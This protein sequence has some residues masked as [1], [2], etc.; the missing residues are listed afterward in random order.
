M[1]WDYL[2][3]RPDW[4]AWAGKITGMILDNEDWELIEVMKCESKLKA[5]IEHAKVVLKEAGYCVHTRSDGK[6]AVMKKR[7]DRPESSEEEDKKENDEEENEKLAKLVGTCLVE[8][9]EEAP[10]ETKEEAEEYVEVKKEEETEDGD[11]EGRGDSAEVQEYDGQ[12]GET[13]M[14]ETAHGTIVPRENE[15]ELEEAGNRQK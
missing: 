2:T 7:R 15:G 8:D 4:K 14:T 6:Q 10:K 3:D 9:D 1:N 5:S 11:R 12:S 13:G